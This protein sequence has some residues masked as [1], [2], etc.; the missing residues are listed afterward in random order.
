MNHDYFHIQTHSTTFTA[1]GNTTISD[2]QCSQC[3]QF[4]LFPEDHSD[5]K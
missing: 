2:Y 4:I 3:A 1:I 5:I